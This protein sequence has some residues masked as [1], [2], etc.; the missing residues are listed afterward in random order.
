MLVI[1]NTDNVDSKNSVVMTS[2]TEIHTK[3]KVFSFIRIQ[4]QNII[5]NLLKNKNEA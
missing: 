5:D 2:K 1:T 3:Q 4:E